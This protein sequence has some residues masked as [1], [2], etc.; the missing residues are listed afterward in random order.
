MYQPVSLASCS[1][2]VV[3][4][5]VVCLSTRPRHDGVIYVRLPEHLWISD[6]VE[7]PK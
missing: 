7:K 4:M 5:L 2:V 6:E 1:D 3:L